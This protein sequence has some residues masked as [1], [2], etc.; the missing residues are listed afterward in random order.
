MPCPLW[1]HPVH[2][3][4]MPGLKKTREPIAL[5]FLLIRQQISLA[6][7]SKYA[8]KA[9]TPLIVIVPSQKLESK[10]VS[11]KQQISILWSWRWERSW[12][13]FELDLSLQAFKLTNLKSILMI[14]GV[15]YLDWTRQESEHPQS[16]SWIQNLS[17][18]QLYYNEQDPQYQVEISTLEPYKGKGANQYLSL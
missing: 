11:W 3:V 14:T 16:G 18:C 9:G 15:G 7:P 1:Q 17:L 13:L 8:E 12:F 6:W 10:L 5:R 4:C 2:K